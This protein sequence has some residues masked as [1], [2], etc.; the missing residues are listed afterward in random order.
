[1][2][3]DAPSPNLSLLRG[4][5]CELLKRKLECVSGKKPF[6][7]IMDRYVGMMLGFLYRLIFFSS[8]YS[9]CFVRDDL[10]DFLQ[11]ADETVGSVGARSHFL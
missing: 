4:V 10:I 6:D 11:L 1:M 8:Y 5:T 2:K 3:G 7:L 9:V